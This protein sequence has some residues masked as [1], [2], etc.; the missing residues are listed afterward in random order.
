M[1]ALDHAMKKVDEKVQSWFLKKHHL[2]LQDK[3]MRRQENE[4][5]HFCELQEAWEVLKG[6]EHIL[7]M[8]VLNGASQ[9]HERST[10]RGTP[11]KRSHHVTSWISSDRCG[12]NDS[13]NLKVGPKTSK[14]FQKRNIVFFKIHL[15]QETWIPLFYQLF[16][17][18]PIWNLTDDENICCSQI[19]TSL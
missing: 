18:F 11:N 19:S 2:Q 10:Q 15:Q 16:C 12:R 17:D 13:W 6:F 4:C 5:I 14:S 1:T 8:W 7:E 9:H 3:R